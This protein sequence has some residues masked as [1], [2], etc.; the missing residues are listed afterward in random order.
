MSGLEETSAADPRCQPRRS[1]SIEPPAVGVSSIPPICA[2]CTEPILPGE[3]RADIRSMDAHRECS[4]RSTLG[5][6]GH[7]LDHAHFCHGELGTD[8]GLDRRTSALMVDIWVMRNGVE[9]AA[10]VP[11]G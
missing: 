11:T 6:I 9:A 2:H 8:A 10:K 7:L 5:G 3:D 1:G 4:L